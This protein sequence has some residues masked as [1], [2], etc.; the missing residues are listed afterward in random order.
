[1]N[2]GYA[3][4]STKD[5]NPDLQLADLNDDCR[6]RRLGRPAQSGYRIAR[7]PWPLS[8]GAVEP[9]ARS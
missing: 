5:Q 6:L 2:I 4:V 9:S 3:Q 8:K 1:M 7:L